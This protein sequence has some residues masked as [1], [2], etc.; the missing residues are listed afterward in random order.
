MSDGGGRA[1]CNRATSASMVR[2][3]RHEACL[4]SIFQQTSVTGFVAV[5]LATQ[6][7]AP[8]APHGS[9]CRSSISYSTGASAIN[10]YSGGRKL[11]PAR[12]S[13]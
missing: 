3:T 5:I 10:C 4:F 6:R 2:S 8:P 7:A 9:P 11:V 12:G 13:R 1:S